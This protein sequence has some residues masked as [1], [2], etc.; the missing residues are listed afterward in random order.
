[1][2]AHIYLDESG[3][4][5]WLFDYPYT[6]GGSSRYLVIAACQLAPEVDY[7]P[8]RLLRNIYKHR[9]WKPGSEKNG[10]ACLHRLELTSPKT[11]LNW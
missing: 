10:L 9:H 6:R 1:M 2:A 5:G 11:L 3:D 7:K 8:E 4:I